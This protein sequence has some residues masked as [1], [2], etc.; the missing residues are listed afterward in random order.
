MPNLRMLLFLV[1]LIPAALSAQEGGQSFIAH[2]S[3]AQ[4]EPP[5]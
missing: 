3:G 4:E 1:A 5:G 2:L